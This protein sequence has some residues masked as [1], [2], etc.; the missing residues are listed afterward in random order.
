MTKKILGLAFIAVFSIQP[1]MA[2]NN[3]AKAK[4]VLE[5]VSKKIKSLKSVKA[6]FALHLSGGGGKV[7]ETK[8]G[9][10]SMKGEKYHVSL[11]GQEIICDTK[12]IW[13]YTKD[14]NEVQI[15]KFDPKEQTI[16]PAKLFT[17]FYDKEYKYHYI[18]QKKI[19][20]KNC[21]VIEMTPINQ[22]KKFAK[23]EISVDKATSVVVGGNVWEK[24][25]N[26]YA[27][28]ISGF[29]PNANIPDNTFTFD[30]KAHPGVEVVD[31]R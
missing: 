15:S 26:K 19:A 9:T 7:N 17:D 5:N 23:I 31:L 22:D 20:G 29:T 27:Y 8:K 14:A 16:S 25:G 6:N 4:A 1:L 18:G 30:P 2:Q 3:D 10:F 12:T 28:D 11:N 24:N 21:D 13:T